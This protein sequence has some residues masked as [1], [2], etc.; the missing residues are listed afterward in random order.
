MTVWAVQAIQHDI[1]L[2]NASD[3]NY[4][5]SKLENSLLLP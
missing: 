3:I 5:P 2:V 4:N 1:L